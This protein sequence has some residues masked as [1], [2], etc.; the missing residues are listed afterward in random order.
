VVMTALL[1][2]VEAARPGTQLSDPIPA[3]SIAMILKVMPPTIP[4]CR[5]RQG[6]TAGSESSVPPVLVLLMRRLRQ[7]NNDAFSPERC[8]VYLVPTQ[9]GA[10]VSAPAMAG[11]SATTGTGLPAA[12][13]PFR[14]PNS[15]PAKK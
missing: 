13:S 6:S 4:A 10:S 12:G 7:G 5:S 9:D 11:Q 3:G 1:T 15:S 2:R 8:G 14:P